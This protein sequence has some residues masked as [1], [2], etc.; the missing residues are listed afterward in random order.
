VK[1]ISDFQAVAGD[2]V[3]AAN[4]QRVEDCIHTLELVSRD[5]ALAQIAGPVRTVT[6]NLRILSRT[7][8]AVDA[9]RVGKKTTSE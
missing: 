7:M 2:V 4:R 9:A 1:V 6:E 3:D 8:S 5:Q